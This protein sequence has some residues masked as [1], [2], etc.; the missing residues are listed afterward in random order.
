MALLIILLLILLIGGVFPVA[1]WGGW[2]N[3]GYG[4]S[5]VLGIVLIVLLVLF[6]FGRL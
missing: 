4:P 1:P 3:L 2:H 5:S 6:L